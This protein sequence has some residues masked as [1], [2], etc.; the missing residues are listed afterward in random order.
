[1]SSTTLS[2]P[3]HTTRTARRIHVA[4]VRAALTEIA[5][6]HPDRRDPRVRD[7]LPPRYVHRGEPACLVALVLIRLGFSQGVLKALD[8]E[9]PTGAL[10][11][12]G[13]RL[14]ESRHPALRKIDPVARQLLQYVQDQ[15]DRGQRWADIVRAA[16][17]PVKPFTFAGLRW[18][19]STKP[20]LVES[21][22]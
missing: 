17:T 16:F 1:M 4:D 5:A 22:R 10:C 20:W 11:E 6:R 13:V 2:R 15:Q 18:P 12:A 19:T 8:Q 21:R 14:A 9:H 7:D 3:T